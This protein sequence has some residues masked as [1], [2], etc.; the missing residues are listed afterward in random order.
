[1]LDAADEVD[2]PVDRIDVPDEVRPIRRGP[3]RLHARRT[4]DRRILTRALL[5]PER[6]PGLGGLRQQPLDLLAALDV[7][8]RTRSGALLAH[9]RVAESADGEVV[10]DQGLDLRVRGGHE[11]VAAVLRID[12]RG[13]E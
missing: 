12:G 3:G 10:A 5:G 4:T 2:R 7:R 1:M 6:G 13:G 9:H 11:V 8:Q